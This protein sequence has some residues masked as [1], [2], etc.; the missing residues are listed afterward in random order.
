MTRAVLR[1]FGRSASLEELARLL[2]FLGE[3]PGPEAWE[4]LAHGLMN[5]KE[6]RYL[7]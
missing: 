6:F 2:D 3:E 5:A 7:R 4:D 1:A